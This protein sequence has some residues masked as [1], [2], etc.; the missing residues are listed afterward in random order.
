MINT[1]K[2]NNAQH[3]KPLEKQNYRTKLKNL[4]K[5]ELNIYGKP[6]TLD[7]LTS[8]IE[9]LTQECFPSKDY[10]RPWQ[11]RVLVPRVEDK[12][13]FGQ[14]MEDT[15][16]TCVTLNLCTKEDIDSY[17]QGGKRLI[18]L[19]NRLARMAKE[20]KEQG[21]L[22][23]QAVAAIL[24]G[25]R[26]ETVSHLVEDYQKRTGKIIPLR[27]IVHDIGRSLSHKKWIVSL[28]EKG[29][30]E[31]EISYLTD[32]HLSSISRYLRRYKQVK[33]L[34]KEMKEEPTIER[35]ARLLRI[36]EY[37]AREY[38]HL[39]TELKQIT[40]NNKAIF[41][42]RQ[43]YREEK[44]AK[45]DSN[46]KSEEKNLQK[47]PKF[48]RSQGWDTSLYPPSSEEKSLIHNEIL[49]PV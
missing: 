44:L 1:C 16:I 47:C 21:G 8:E 7:L 18:F 5:E 31:Q 38:L 17:Y 14:S 4:L 30:T 25:V 6:K 45:E 15:Q 43:E 9:Q 37:L 27:G 29:Y 32:H 26:Q 35:I 20:A 40:W 23:S 48:Q 41:K 34:I 10:L 24:L 46:S 33:E 28:Y 42:S 3:Y 36:S 22:L 13:H 11:V 12:P 19:Q 49:S 2:N 39:L